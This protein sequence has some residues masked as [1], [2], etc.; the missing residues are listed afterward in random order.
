LGTD[1]RRE[2]IRFDPDKN[3]LAIIHVGGDADDSL[4]GLLRDESYRGCSAVFH[5]EHFPYEDGT[6]VDLKVEPDRPRP[7]DIVWTDD[8]DERLLR[9]GFHFVDDE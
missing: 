1:E 9:V 8:L 4:V 3:A 7:A 6:T 2:N 5:S